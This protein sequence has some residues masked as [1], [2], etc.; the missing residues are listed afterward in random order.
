[1]ANSARKPKLPQGK[2][3]HQCYTEHKTRRVTTWIDETPG[4]QLGITSRIESCDHG[5]W[6]FNIML[7][8]WHGLQGRVMVFVRYCACHAN[9]HRHLWRWA[10]PETEGR[11]SY[12]VLDTLTDL[13]HAHRHATMS[14]ESDPLEVREQWLN[15]TL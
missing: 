14:I 12:G 2:L 15:G 13:R 6:D 5:V 8:S 3:Q 11:R 7:R 9:Y 1:M 10:A 4:E